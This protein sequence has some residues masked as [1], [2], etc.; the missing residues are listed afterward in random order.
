MIQEKENTA[1]YATLIAIVAK[2]IQLQNGNGYSIDTSVFPNEELLMS[3]IAT[4][5]R[6]LLP[7]AG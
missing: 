5:M 4:R 7:L 3:A 6:Y 1:K 2:A